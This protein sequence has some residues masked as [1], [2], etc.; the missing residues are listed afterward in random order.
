VKSDGW[1]P[2]WKGPRKGKVAVIG[3]GPAG[4]TAAYFL[5]TMGR[6]VKVFE[7][8]NVTGGLLSVGIPQYRLPRD[9]LDRDIDYI[10][11][12]GVEIETG[13]KVSSIKAL[14]D[15]GYDAVFVATGAHKSTNL[16]IP[17]EDLEGVVDALAFLRSAL[18]GEA[19]RMQGAAVVIGGGNAAVDAAR[20]ALRLGAS[21]VTILYRRTKEE[22]PA[23]PEEVEDALQEGIQLKP[24]V[25]PI[26]VEGEGRVSAVRCQEMELGEADESGRRRP[27]AKA[28]AEVVVKADHV[29]VSIGQG[30]DLDFED[31]E[32]S[33]VVSRGR[34]VADVVSQKSGDA[35][36]FAGGDAVTGPSSIIEAIAAGQR[37]AVAIDKYLG[38]T[39]QLPEDTARAPRVRPSEEQA[40]APRQHV[41]HMAP[42]IRIRDFAEVAGGLSLEAACAEACR[43]LRC[44]LE[45]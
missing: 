38:G 39:G 4:L 13:A 26:A 7:A 12:A 9:I 27:V 5:A 42:G 32:G 29:I 11:K 33:L 37:A 44:D 15:A 25:A 24:L 34:I 16:G 36:V 28:G 22:M 18:A 40:A 23:I 41:C 30:P 17:G 3:S 31:V 6:E 43:C 2:Q 8:L 1:P 14:R 45:E 21:P 19:A 20:T 35:G 10:K